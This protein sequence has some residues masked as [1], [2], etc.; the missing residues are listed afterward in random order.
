MRLLR[1]RCP[2]RTHL[3]FRMRFPGRCPGW[4]ALPRWGN[5]PN[6]SR[7][8]IRP[9]LGRQLARRRQDRRH[10]RLAGA[11]THQKPHQYCQQDAKQQRFPISRKQVS[12]GVCGAWKP[13]PQPHLPPCPGRKLKFPEVGPEI[14]QDQ[15][16]AATRHH[17]QSR[18]GQSPPKRPGQ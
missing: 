4:Y 9:W 5:W 1:I 12:H 8:T 7:A 13:V 10:I 6:S 3:F 2:F 11:L 18:A 17:K 15:D 14:H 16:C